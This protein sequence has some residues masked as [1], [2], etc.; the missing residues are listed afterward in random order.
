[1]IA[2]ALAMKSHAA[3]YDRTVNEARRRR[4]AMK[5]RSKTVLPRS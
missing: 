1:V 5:S 4:Q 2:H 3:S